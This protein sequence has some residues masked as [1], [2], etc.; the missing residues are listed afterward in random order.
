MEGIQ[1]V[2]RRQIVFPPV[3]SPHD[4]N[5]SI[6]H[7]H[8]TAS[9][10]WRRQSTIQCRPLLVVVVVVVI[11]IAG[12]TAAPCQWHPHLIRCIDPLDTI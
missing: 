10:S 9:L 6:V 1:N 2:H 5:V 8:R 11:R 12:P 4:H 3:V 7:R